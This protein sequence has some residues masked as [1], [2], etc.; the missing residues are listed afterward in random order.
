MG[1]RR[2][3]GES[4]PG[5][6]SDGG[7]GAG[8][9]GTFIHHGRGLD[10]VTVLSPRCAGFLRTELE[11]CR[12]SRELIRCD[13]TACRAQCGTRAIAVRVPDTK[14]AVQAW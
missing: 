12:T 9:D 8:T 1:P 7:H 2:F 6:A 4:H 14:V 10:P 3:V 5:R 13:L 11:A